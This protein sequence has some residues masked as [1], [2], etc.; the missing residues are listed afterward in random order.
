MK[1][2]RALLIVGCLVFAVSVGF[3]QQAD[4][5][6]YADF[7]TVQG[8][9]PVSNHGG[10]IQLLA[11][12]ERSTLPSHFKGAGTTDAP[13]LVHLKKDDPNRAMTF[14]YDMQATN[15][16][17]GVG[18]QIHGEPD[19]DGKPVPDDVSAYKFLTFQLY[20]TGVTSMSAEFISKG[21]GLDINGG[22]PSMTFR[23]SPG[24]NVYKIP[25]SSLNQP[26][27]AE[28]RL[29]TKDVLKKLTSVQIGVSCNDCQT[30]TKG[31]VVIDNLVFQ[32]L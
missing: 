23:V 28:K 13:E 10:Y 6:V 16:Y 1:N 15:Q 17:A 26:T 5:L 11:Y 24:F 3:S 29:N 14:A 30:T 7:E 18:V 32:N 19:K 20:V 9:R 2:V 8:D 25:L 31:T 4:K 27:W 12:S 22:Y 21:Q